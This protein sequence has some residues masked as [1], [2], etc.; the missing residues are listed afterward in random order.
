ME[1]PRLFRLSLNKSGFVKDFSKSNGFK[2]VDWAVFF[3]RHLLD[4]EVIM[5]SQLMKAVSCIVL[6][7][8]MEDRL[9]WIH[10]KQGE[11]SVRKLSELLICAETAIF[12]FAFDRIGNLKVPPKLKS[13]LWMVSIDRIPTK[14]FLGK[15]GVKFGQLGNGCPWCEREMVSLEHFLFN[16]NFIAG[17]WRNILELWEVKWRP[18]VDFSDFFFFCNNVLY[19]GVVKSLWLISMSVACWS[20]WPARNEL[21]FEKRWPKMSN[22]V[23]LTKILA[24]MWI[25]AVYDELKV[26]EKI[27]WVCPYK[28]WSDIKKFGLNGMFWCPPSLGWVKINVCGVEIEDKVGC[29]G[30]LRDSDGVARALFSGPFA[31]KDSLVVEVGAIS[32]AL[33]VFLAMGW[34]GKCSLIIKVGSIEVFNWVENKLDPLRRLI[35]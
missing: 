19:K 33:T 31:A 13:F 20:V 5:V 27:W 4:R 28:S 16:C 29:G 24:L 17:F 22:L 10:D 1:F 2:E 25:R 14:E 30:V 9:I 11:F 21:V 15:S 35:R 8:E 34:K 7:P 6:I 26:D 23:F 3:S 32:L 12:R 18:F